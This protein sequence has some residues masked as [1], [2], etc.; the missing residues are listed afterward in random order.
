MSLEH[1]HPYPLYYSPPGQPMASAGTM[2][3]AGYPAGAYPMAAGYAAYGSQPPHALPAATYPP[4]S[5]PFFN[6]S[7][8]RFLKGLLIG[9]AAAYVVTN[10]DVQRTAIKGVVKVWSF[11]QGG[12][13]EIKERFHDAEAELHAAE[14]V[15]EEAATSKG[16]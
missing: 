6:F 5:S 8:D 9:A 1:H 16:A 4:A 12:L 14:L 2:A 11:L 3:P 7:N 15:E 10:E 13:E